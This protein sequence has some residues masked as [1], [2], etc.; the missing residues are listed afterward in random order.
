MLFRAVKYR[1]FVYHEDEKLRRPLMGV[2]VHG[3][4][5]LP[6]LP[7]NNYS[8][9]IFNLAYAQDTEGLGIIY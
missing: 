7:R 9:P 8:A 3:N 4:H 6:L 2:Y 5:F 1:P